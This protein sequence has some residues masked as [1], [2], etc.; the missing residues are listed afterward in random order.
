MSVTRVV[1]L[2]M[3]VL[4]VSS[5]GLF[6]GGKETVEIRNDSGPATS[7]EVRRV[8]VRASLSKGEDRRDFTV[9]VTPFQAIQEQALESGRY[10][11][12]VYCLITYGG[13]DITWILGPDRPVE[14][15][16]VQNDTVTLT[17]RCTQR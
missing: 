13:S 5:C 8:R 9:N 6:R 15:M 7:A 11:A 2:V 10:K 12:T 3:V 16:S 1:C 17:G 14:E 4:G